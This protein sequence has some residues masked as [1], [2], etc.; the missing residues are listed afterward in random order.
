MPT[1][2]SYP[3][4][5]EVD[6]AYHLIL[7]V[8]VRNLNEYHKLNLSLRQWSF[9]LDYWLHLFITSFLFHRKNTSRENAENSVLEIPFSVEEAFNLCANTPY[10]SKFIDRMGSFSPPSKLRRELIENNPSI[11]VKFISK[12]LTFLARLNIWFGITD[13]SALVCSLGLFR[14]IFANPLLPLTHAFFVFERPVRTL[15]PLDISF[16]KMSRYLSGEGCVMDVLF[17]SVSLSIP[18]IYLEDFGSYCQ[19]VQPEKS[20]LPAVVLSDVSHIISDPFKI[21]ISINDLINVLVVFRHGG[22]AI[23]R[24]NVNTDLDLKWSRIYFRSGCSNKSLVDGQASIGQYWSDLDDV[25]DANGPVTVIYQD[26]PRQYCKIT[27]AWPKPHLLGSYFASVSRIQYCINNNI[28]PNL[29]YLHPAKGIPDELVSSFPQFKCRK[30]SFASQIAKSK[31]VI[32]TYNGSSFYQTIG[33][34]IPTLVYLDS[35]IW[36]LGEEEVFFFDKLV[37]V[38]VLHRAFGDLMSHLNS[39]RDVEE[40]WYSKEVQ[41]VVRGFQDEFCKRDLRYP[42]HVMKYLEGFWRD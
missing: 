1:D 37:S 29:E 22:G 38:G 20:C 32:V 19:P 16:R 2:I 39:L 8:L 21:F 35:Q 36:E 10:C 15:A 40:W 12:A 34:N 17:K 26:Y 14:K 18:T 33:S 7:P 28:H 11:F 30:G 41:T 9:I 25:Y 3:T 4:K 24:F 5:D 13:K 31:L 27:S 23:H 42:E 6:D